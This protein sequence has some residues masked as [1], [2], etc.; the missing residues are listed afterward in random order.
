MKDGIKKL[1]KPVYNGGKMLVY[2]LLG[3]FWERGLFLNANAKKLYRYR[4]VHKGRRCFLVGAGPSLTAE[5]LDRIEGEISIGC[6]MLYKFYDKTRWRP[7]YYC[8]TDRVYA[9]YQSREMTDHV[10]API[11]TPKSTYVR[12]AGD[13]SKMISVHDIYDYNVYK[14]RGKML[15]YCWLKASVMLFMI[16]LAV[17]M[18]FEEIYLL[19]VDCTSTY[20]AKNHHFTED[21]ADAWTREAEQRR[22]RRDLKRRQMTPEEMGAHNY[23]RQME[24]FAAVKAFADKKGVR[25]YN[26]TRGGELEVFPRTTLEKALGV[27]YNKSV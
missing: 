16:E 21:Y 12:M 2:S 22:M 15:S 13:K 3:F 19:G 14:L 24:G 10:D 7:Q 4:N 9:K 8:M 25:I 27:C 20:T 17:Y 5:D 18:G 6:N 26:A 11:F 23:R 1:L